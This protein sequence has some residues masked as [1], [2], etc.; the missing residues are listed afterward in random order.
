M[1]PMSA[2]TIVMAT[3]GQPGASKAASCLNDKLDQPSSIAPLGR[4]SVSRPLTTM[5]GVW[6]AGYHR[7]PRNSFLLMFG[8][9]LS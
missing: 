4:W 1:M 5:I 3:G 2:V 6:S 9:R 8:Q 7:P